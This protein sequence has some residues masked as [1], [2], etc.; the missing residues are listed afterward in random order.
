TAAQRRLD[1]TDVVEALGPVQIDDQVHAGAAHA[2]ANGEMAF[3]PLGRVALNHGDVSDVLSGG[4]WSCQAL[5]RSQEG[6]LAHV[7]PPQPSDPTRVPMSGVRQANA[8]DQPVRK[9][10]DHSGLPPHKAHTPGVKK[11][12]LRRGLE[13]PSVARFGALSARLAGP[14][15]AHSADRGRA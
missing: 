15:R 10:T 11:I 1:Q 7:R 6:V 9:G 13:T 12:L 3:A 4:A 14:N 8:A 2:V 5:P